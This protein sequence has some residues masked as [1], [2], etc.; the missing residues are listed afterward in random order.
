MATL[1]PEFSASR[2]IRD[3]TNDHYLP[4]ATG[5]HARATNDGKLGTDLMQWQQSIARGWDTLRFGKVSV[6][7][8]DGQH[9]FQIEVVPGVLHPEQFSV[10][11]YAGPNGGTE[12]EPEI[13]PEILAACESSAQPSG[14]IVYSICCAAKR[15]AADY[16]A[17]IVPSHTGA[18]VP[19]EAN[20]VLWAR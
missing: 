6:E 9:R 20:Q 10:E 14:T 4:A 18:S 13:D 7:T 1:T 5:Y 19:L 16:T 2:A 17:R 12:T 8:R 15:A 3:Y 11:L